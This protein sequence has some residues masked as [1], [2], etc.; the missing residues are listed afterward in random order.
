MPEN[1]CAGPARTPKGEDGRM[2]PLRGL[3]LEDLRRRTSLKWC[4]YEA[5]V[6]PLWVAEMDVAIAD[7]VR[8]ALARAVRDSDTGYPDAKPYPEALAKFAAD[9][10]SW[11]GLDPARTALVVDVMVGVYE[12]IRLVSSPGDPVVVNPPAYPPFY[13]FI[14]H[15][16]RSV[17]EVPLRADGRLDLGALESAFARTGSGGGQLS[18]LLCNPHNPTG[19][20]HTLAELGAVAVLADRYRVRVI[21]DEI[22]APLVSGP[23][24]FTPYLSVPGTRNAFSVMSA[25]KAWN[26]AGVKGAVIVGGEDTTED[27][28][29]IP[30]IVWHGLSHLGVIAHTAALNDGREW[31]D[32]LRADLDENRLLLSS[33]LARHLPAV[34]CRPEPGTYLAW[35]DCREIGLGDDPAAAFLERGRVA[36]SPG[37]EFGTGGAGHVRL[38]Y[39]TTPEILEEAIVRMAAVGS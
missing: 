30:E 5:D 38:N 6:L 14:E 7:P 9:R 23:V 35:L 34:G 3:S 12:A 32:A 13:G 18:Y 31:L 24:P 26:L 22:H 25:S 11:T 33:L 4:T 27:L 8:D 10:W 39:G 20:V 2:H 21:A 16:E 15:A 29:R 28:A 37:L 17:V 36:L 1:G 19:V